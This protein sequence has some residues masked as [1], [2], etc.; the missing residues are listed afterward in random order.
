M[1]SLSFFVTDLKVF[2]SFIK[3]AYLNS[4]KVDVKYAE[5][6]LTPGVL[7]VILGNLIVMAS[8]NFGVESL[9]RIISAW[10]IR[11]VKNVPIH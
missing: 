8:K 3:P 1:L 4:K 6:E 2:I 9:R 7:Q 5:H 11:N 10:W